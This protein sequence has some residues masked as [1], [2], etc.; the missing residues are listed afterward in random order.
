MLQLI[1]EPR[2]LLDRVAAAL[3]PGGVVGIGVSN[4][5][6]TGARLFGGAWRGLGLPRHISHFTPETLERLLEW[7]GFEVVAR[8]YETPRWVV[9]GSVDAALPAPRPVRRAA[10]AGLYA[11]KEVWGR[12]RY[13]DTMEVYARLRRR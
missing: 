6:S 5:R 3:E 8:R 9:A 11:A 13:A 10:K 2:A 12:T 4:I 1:Y 7:A